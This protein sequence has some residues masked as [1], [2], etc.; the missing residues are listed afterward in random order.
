MGLP[1]WHFPKCGNKW[2]QLISFTWTLEW[3]LACYLVV[4]VTQSCPTLCDHLGLY[5]PWKSP[6][7]NIGV[8]SCSLLQG[9]FPTEGSNPGLPHCRWMLYQLSHWGSPRI[10]E[11]VAYPFSREVSQPRDQTVVSHTAGGFF[12]N[13]ATTREA[14]DIRW[15]NEKWK[16]VC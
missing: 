12:T 13:W 10:L 9:I 14:C 5:S 2:I 8:S 1:C 7:Q 4:K 3:W 16:K 11:W 6:G 15:W